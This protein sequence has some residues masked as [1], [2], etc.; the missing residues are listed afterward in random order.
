[1]GHAETKVQDVLHA[2]PVSMDAYWMP[3]RRIGFKHDPKMV[4]RAEGMYLSER[5][6]RAAD[7]CVVRAVLR[8]AGH[9]ARKSP[10]RSA[11]RLRELDFIAPFTRGHPKQSSLQVA[12]RRMTP[13]I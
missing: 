11:A 9:A 5:A 2:K 4:V 3:S 12:W 10:T 13:A 6:R 7:R 8:N 1:M